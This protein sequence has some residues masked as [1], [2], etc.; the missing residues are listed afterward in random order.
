VGSLRSVRQV[1][2]WQLGGVLKG[3]VEQLVSSKLQPRVSK[4]T[5]QNYLMLM[6]G[7]SNGAMNYAAIPLPS[8]PTEV[9]T[10]KDLPAGST[11]PVTC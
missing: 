2:E 6:A 8:L 1:V 4:S 10:A 9:F 3:A 11:G 7:A 5:C